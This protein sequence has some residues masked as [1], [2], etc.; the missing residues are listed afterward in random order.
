MLVPLAL[1]SCGTLG[2]PFGNNAGLVTFY[3]N[4]TY[5]TNTEH[6]EFQAANQYPDLGGSA[7]GTEYRVLDGAT[8]VSSRTAEADQFGDVLKLWKGAMVSV[9]VTQNTPGGSPT[10]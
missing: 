4:P 10:S 2:R 5:K 7:T 3:T 6:V 9:A 1:I 8:V